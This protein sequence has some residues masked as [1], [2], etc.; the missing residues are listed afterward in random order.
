MPT[1]ALYN[2][3]RSQPFNRNTKDNAG[4][5]EERFDAYSQALGGAGRFDHFVEWYIYLHKRTISDISSSIKELEQQVN[6]LQRSVDG[7]MVSVK[8][9]LEQM[10]L[11]LSEASRRNDAAVSSKW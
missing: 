1:F 10:K 8:S 3:E 6:D 5:R 7:G 4:R 11:K 9:L 2:V